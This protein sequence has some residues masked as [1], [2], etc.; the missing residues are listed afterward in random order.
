VARRR[1]SVSVAVVLLVLG[2]LGVVVVAVAWWPLSRT[3]GSQ[4]AAERTA[5]ATVIA[6]APC[7]ASTTGDVVQVPVDGTPRQA[8]LDGCG[9]A[10]G[11]QLQVRV[12]ATAGGGDLVV[13]L[14]QTSAGDG[15]PSRLSWVLL[16]LAAIAGGGYMMLLRS[17][18]TS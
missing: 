9:H 3:L 17:R 16:T 18:P 11:Q 7:G 4:P 2:L 12:P 1:G 15:T 14:G 8:H 10:R 5:T 6:P 13:R